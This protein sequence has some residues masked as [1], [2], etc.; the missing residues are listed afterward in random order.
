M[1]TS[2]GLTLARRFT[3][4]GT[5]PFSIAWERRT[6]AIR[7][8]AGRVVFE[9]EDVEVP[10]GWSETATRVVASKYFR[11]RLGTARREHS[12]RQ[13]VSRV[14]ETIAGWAREA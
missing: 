6:A 12:V 13:L 11:G 14:V 5:D 7:D 10:A 3:R 8:G 1:L 4:P 9:Q 2:A